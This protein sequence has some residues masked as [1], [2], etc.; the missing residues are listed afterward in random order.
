M[1]TATVSGKLSVKNIVAWILTIAIPSALLLPT[2]EV[3]TSQIK[4]F[5][6]ITMVAVLT[7]IF[8]HINSTAATLALPLVYI[9]VLKVPAAQVLSPW[10]MSVPWMMVGGFFLAI[11]LQRVGLL[12]RVAYKC[13]MITGAS[14]NGIIWGLAITG[15]VLYLMM[16]N[17]TVVPLA[18]LG[19]SIC[20]ALGLSKGREAAG[21]TLAAATAALVPNNF[22]FNSTIFVYAGMGQAAA[23]P[24]SIGYVEYFKENFVMLFY[25]FL[26][27][28]VI[29]KMFKPRTPINGK[30][31]FQQEYEKLGK[32]T[33]EEKKVLIVVAILFV[34]LLTA[35]LH[36]IDV[37]LGFA[38]IPLLLFLPG[39]K[40]ATAEDL[41]GIN[42][43]VVVFTVGCLSI[44]TTG[45]ALGLGQM[46]AG[47]IMPIIEGRSLTFFLALVY[48]AYIVL[49]FILTPMAMTAAFTLPLAQIAVDIGLNPAA[50][51]VF[52]TSATDQV[53]LPYEI[54]VYLIF[55]GFGMVETKHFAQFMG[56]RMLFNAIFL[57]AF[58]IPWWSFTGFLYL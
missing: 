42:W 24:I 4:L 41:N 53:I 27:F 25:Y 31:F 23:G 38:I 8:E 40:V 37:M 17:N 5:L 22:L 45:G 46:A 54:A 2:N 3:F 49:N 11:I 34:F 18:V 19:F 48:I 43:S 56:V 9:I 50:L 35:K 16:S 58:P 12:K 57:F 7:F 14:Y 6:A 36:G 33:S 29:T 30:A 51:Y 1:S 47:W 28:F 39:L 13:I 26:L 32:I 52:F 21:I 10:T 15:L 20:K 44:G 55:L